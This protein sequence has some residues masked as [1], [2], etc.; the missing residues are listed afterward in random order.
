M[1][2]LIPVQDNASAPFALNHARILHRNLLTGATAS[3]GSGSNPAFS[4]LPNTFERFEFTATVT[5]TYVLPSNVTIDTVCVG[6]HNLGNKYSVVVSYKSTT[7]GTIVSFGAKTP[8]TNDAI[9]LHSASKANIKELIITFT[10]SG[11]GYVGVTSAGIAMQMPR[12]FFSGHSPLPLSAVTQYSNSIT[13]TGQFVGREIKSRGFETSV[14]WDNLP[15]S[16]VRGDFFAFIQD[17]KLL[18][19]F[20]AWNLLLYP[21]DVGYVAV[22]EDITPTLNGKRTLMSVGFNLQG[23]G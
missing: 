9:M 14:S 1:G 3:A 18:P 4:L 5:L 16:F 7:G 13:E 6:A 10:G 15:S 12:P 8:T 23:H 11:S 20:F 21:D 19:F 17:A 2:L 22:N